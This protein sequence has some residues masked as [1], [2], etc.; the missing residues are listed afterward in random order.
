MDLVYAVTRDG[1]AGYVNALFT[2]YIILIFIRIL[3]TWIPRLPYNQIVRSTV[4]FV[5][6]VTDPY[7]N[8]FRRIIPPI[9]A[10][11]VGIDLSPILAMIVLFIVQ[12]LVVGAIQG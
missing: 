7:L 5:A 2:V 11:G 9:G 10:G 12:S 4:E 8:V 1:A 6:E 3:L